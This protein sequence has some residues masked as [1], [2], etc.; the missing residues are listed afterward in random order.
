[1]DNMSDD[2]GKKAGFDTAGAT[3]KLYGLLP[4]MLGLYIFLNPFPA[5]SPKEIVFY[6]MVLLFVSLA[7][8]TR[9]RFSFRSPLT[10]PF[11]LF[12]AWALLSVLFALDFRSSLNDFFAHLIKFYLLYYMLINLFNSSQR[13]ETLSWLIILSTAIFAI[14]IAL[15]WYLVLGQPLTSRLGH[16]YQ[17]Y[18]TVTNGYYTVFG[19][20]LALRQLKFE[21]LPMRKWILWISSLSL[22][23]V[24]VLS[25]ARSTLLALLVV[26]I[27]LYLRKL[28]VMLA[29]VLFLIVF[30]AVMPVKERFTSLAGVT[31]RA[32][33]LLYTAEIIKDYPVF[34]IGYSVDTFRDDSRIDRDHY[35]ARLP[36]QYQNLADPYLWPHNMFFDVAARTGLPGG[37]LFTLFFIVPAVM[38]L[39]IVRAAPDETIKS[40]GVCGLACLSMFFVKGSLEQIF[41]A[42]AEIIFFSILAMIT[43]AWNLRGEAG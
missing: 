40:W 17:T 30:I 28:K 20:V 8:F 34:G 25:Q 29:V 15:H 12:A 27:I 35:I 24:S 7:L 5:T 32:G 16:T 21:R 13:L 3:G 31:H 1:M 38:G 6:S 18:G 22:G 37:A 36:Q 26:L 43:I 23:A 10:I 4:Y 42:S 33:L 2:T 11:V 9:E 41:M 14:T 19:L 39:K